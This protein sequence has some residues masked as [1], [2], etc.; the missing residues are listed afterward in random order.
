MAK[1]NFKSV[2]EYIAAQAE[3]AQDAL[4][5]VRD[6]IRQALPEAE[7]TIS[8]QIPVY[9]LHGARVLFFAGWKTYYSL[10]P[11]GARLVAAFQKQLTPYE[12]RKSTIRFPFSKPVPVKLIERIAKFPREGS[13]RARRGESGRREE[14]LGFLGQP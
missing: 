5:R 8:Y 12:V 9:K 4:Q 7:E 6:A 10:Y 1:T 14:G 13:R 11:A 2:D 3:A